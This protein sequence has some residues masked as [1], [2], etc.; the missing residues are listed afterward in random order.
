MRLIIKQETK[1]T[2]TLKAGLMPAC[3]KVVKWLSQ[4]G[5]SVNIKQGFH[6]SI[7]FQ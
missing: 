3:V 2:L 6:V 5:Q 1:L 4:T 7:G